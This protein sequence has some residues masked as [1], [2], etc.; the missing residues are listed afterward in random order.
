MDSQRTRYVNA[1]V[2][3]HLMVAGPLA[4]SII[5]LL[6]KVLGDADAE[7]IDTALGMRFPSRRRCRH[8]VHPRISARELTMPEKT[9]ARKSLTGLASQF[10]Q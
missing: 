3:F 8:V 4:M 7:L 6:L 9:K 10:N 5:A 1:Q 2:R